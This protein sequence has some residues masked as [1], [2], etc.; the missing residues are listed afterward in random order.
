MKSTNSLIPGLMMAFGILFSTQVLSQDKPAESPFTIKIEAEDVAGQEVYL[1]NYYGNKLYYNDTTV[2]DSKGVATFKGKPFEECGKY[3]VVFPGPK[4]FDIL[5]AE[6]DIYIKTK[7]AD[8]IPNLN[9]V[10]SKENQIFYDYL[11][12]I[13]AKKGER[14]PIDEC[15][16]DSLKSDEDKEPCREEL[17]KLNDLVVGKQQE[18]VTKHGDMLVGKIINMALDVEVPE[19]IKEQAE[20]DKAIQY[21]WYRNH[22]WDHVDFSDPRLVRDQ[23]FHRLLE[24]YYTQVLPQIPDSLAN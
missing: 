20:E 17:K 24:K 22:Y 4:V 9:I 2:A 16:R 6:E 21:Y 10:K 7:G 13:S 15:L 5:V 14:A 23:M 1:A 3:A 8:P 12:F 18:V 11:N 19:S